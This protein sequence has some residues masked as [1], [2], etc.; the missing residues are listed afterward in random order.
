MFVY[1]VI[2]NQPIIPTNLTN[3][4]NQVGSN[5]FEVSRK[6]VDGVELVSEKYIA[7]AVLRLLEMEKYV[8]EGGGAAGLAAILPGGPL[9][10]PALKGKCTFGVF[11]F[12]A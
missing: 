8:V 11:F 5:A 10:V 12:H 6:H 3:P 9:D 1:Y 4:T 7:L 2:S